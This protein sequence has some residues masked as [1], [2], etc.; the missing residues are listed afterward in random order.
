MK[1][2]TIAT[3]ALG[4]CLAPAMAQEP[5]PAP[6]PTTEKPREMSHAEEGTTSTL[7]VT[8]AGSSS[9]KVELTRKR[10][11]EGSRAE[12]RVYLSIARTPEVD[13]KLDEL[14]AK[15]PADPA[16]W[17]RTLE[18][19]SHTEID[20]GDEGVA[21]VEELEEIPE[22][23]QERMQRARERFERAL[24]SGYERAREYDPWGEDEEQGEVDR[25]H[26][27]D[28]DVLSGQLLALDPA[29]FKFKTE[30]GELTVARDKVRR[31]DLRRAPRP[32][33]GVTLDEAERGVRIDEVRPG[34]AA[35]SAGLKA[36]DLVFEVEGKP[37]RTPDELR[38]QLWT[39]KP[40]DE[41]ELGVE[42]GVEKIELKAKL[43]GK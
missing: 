14:F 38:R 12:Q 42:R 23:V 11:Q 27:V 2:T 41:V 33:L 34:S 15:R 26:L 20:L 22:R 28:G 5:T 19:L 6:A 39:K 10:E 17:E 3:L 37:V 1:S 7:K 31:I 24:R 16:E 13:Q 43:E 8:P 32:V 35:E 4:L 9:W 18:E 40:G 25:L 30:Y 29:G 21:G 36:G